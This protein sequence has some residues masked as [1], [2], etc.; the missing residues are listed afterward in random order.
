MPV[1]PKLVQAVFL[2]AVETADSAARAAILQD[3]C[4]GD[5][6]LRQRVEALLRAHDR[7]GS[8]LGQPLPP[9]GAEPSTLPP[10][11][12]PVEAATLPPTDAAGGSLAAHGQM[13]VPGYE[14]LGELGRGGMGVVYKARQVGLNRPVALK[15]ILAGSHASAEDLAR[16]RTEAEAVA[17]LQHPHIVQIYEIGDHQDTPYFSQEF[18][19]GGSL[20]KKLSGTPLPPRQAAALVE[21]LARAVH[22]AHQAGIL[23]RDLKPANVLLTA[24]NQPKIADFGLAKKLGEAGQTA[25]GAVMGTPSYMA[26]EQAG[27]KSKELGPAADVYALGAILYECLTG[28]PPFRAATPLDTLL[29]VM[30]EPPVPPRRLQRTVPS[31][32]QTICLKCLEKAPGQRYKSAEALAADLGRFLLGKSIRARRPDII[33]QTEAWLR[34]PARMRDAGLLQLWVA[35]TTAANSLSYFYLSSRVHG[36]LLWSSLL[37]SMAV[38]GAWI[39]LKTIAGKPWALWVGVGFSVL[40]TLRKLNVVFMAPPTSR[41]PDAPWKINF[42][43]PWLSAPHLIGASLELLLVVLSCVAL[44]AYYMN[45][46]EQRVADQVLRQC[47]KCGRDTSQGWPY[48]PYCRVPTVPI[49]R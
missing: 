31:D 17:R 29:Q 49:G 6:E 13:A 26:P 12:F 24:D 36:L 4:G 28:R 3:T 45:R 2:A 9:A 15:M 33:T 19:P 14:I 44:L 25:S 1:D 7:S 20:E 40:Q 48:C 34:H 27:G 35:L 39:G 22:A 16:F 30:S 8:S 47:P 5:A 43:F 10:G 38:L 42:G 46:N 18:C 37:L 21:T 23:H 11:K 41:D 32:L